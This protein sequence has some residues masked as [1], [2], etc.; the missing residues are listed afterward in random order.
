M[1]RSA[2]ILILRGWRAGR[3]NYRACHNPCFG[4]CAD[5]LLHQTRIAAARADRSHGSPQVA[6][7][8]PPANLTA[9]YGPEGRKGLT[10]AFRV[11]YNFSERVAQDFVAE[12]SYNFGCFA[13]NAQFE[14]F[15]LGPVR[16]EKNLLRISTT[17]PNID[18]FGSLK[19]SRLIQRSGD[20]TE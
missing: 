1:Q 17:V 14:R 15:H 16:N 7:N 11:A 3:R 8:L 12:T 2:W 6:S 5:G 10:E 18:T 19:P 13:L 9:S 4:L 20:A